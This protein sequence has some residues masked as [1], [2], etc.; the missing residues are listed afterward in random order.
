MKNKHVAKGHVL[1]GK[2]IPKNG[3]VINIV[4][5]QQAQMLFRKI[6]GMSTDL[7]NLFSVYN[8]IK[9]FEIGK[10]TP[11][12]TEKI[13][14]EQ[15]YVV[16]GDKPNKDKNW[17]PLLRGSLIQRYINLWNYDYWVLYGEWL[18]APRDPKIFEAPQKIMVRQTG[19]SII[20][21]IIEAGF[22]ARN[23]MHIILA[24]SELYKLEYLLGIMNSKLIDFA[25]RF[26]N[27]E[28]GEAL[29]EVKKKH[30]EKL[31]V[32]TINFSNPAEKAQHDKMVALVEQMLSAHKALAAT[33]SPAEKER[34]QRQIEAT[35]RAID[36]LVYELYGLTEEEIRIVEEN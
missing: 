5:D 8:G 11:P 36:S 3:D 1:I 29:V 28:K 13:A 10:G 18:A 35:D 34:I 2:F 20:A 22:V 7:Q 33:Q 14:K 24:K 30:V 19:D 25:Y 6:L 17:K 16:E 21:T 9:P 26:I 4:A 32:R 12:Q 27:P 31:P 23:N 15:P